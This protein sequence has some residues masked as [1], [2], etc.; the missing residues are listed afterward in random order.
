MSSPTPPGVRPLPLSE[1]GL[2]RLARLSEE[3]AAMG[4]INGISPIY[5]G[6]GGRIAPATAAAGQAAPA[7]GTGQ[8]AG[9]GTAAGAT[10]AGAASSILS[11]STTSLTATSETLMASNTPMLASNEAIGAALLLLVLQYLQSSDPNEKQN[12]TDMIIALA[13]MQQSQGA[14]QLLFYSSSSLT[15]E[16]TQLT[17]ATS[18]ALDAYAGTAASMQQAPPADAGTAGLNVT[19]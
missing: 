8:A 17:I 16:S 6:Y 1:R 12:L 4:S 18:Q 15:M 11:L 14:G 5:G 10:Q 19:V 13:G 7:S 3:K 2:V 9:T